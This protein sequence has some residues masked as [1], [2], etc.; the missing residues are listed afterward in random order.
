MKRPVFAASA[1]AAGALFSI[2]L[3]VGCP[4]SLADPPDYSNLPVNPNNI[5][6]STAFIAE[7]PT[8]NPNGQPGVT[9]VFTHRDGSRKV[10]DT[11]LVLSDPG[12]ATAALQGATA[13][14]N[15]KI[16][17]P[18][19]EPAPVGTDG[20]L[21]SGPSQD[22]SQTVTALLFTQGNVAT[23]IRFEGPTSDPVPP[24]LAIDYGQ[25][26]DTAIKNAGLL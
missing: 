19:S 16:A 1:V 14:V 22:G 20:T 8:P 2:G 6:D 25:Q 5:T 26:Q 10:T 9:A 13:D 4:T 23:T 24:D 15:A 3:S 17:N 12:A 11:I 18:K 21:I 7:A